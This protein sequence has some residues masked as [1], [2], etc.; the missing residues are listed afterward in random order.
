[1]T[2]HANR[3]H[4]VL[5]QAPAV[6]EGRA[7]ASRPRV[8]SVSCARQRLRA[9]AQHGGEVSL[10]VSVAMIRERSMSLIP[11]RLLPEI[12]HEHRGEHGC[13]DLQSRH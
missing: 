13:D 5:R 6:A 12:G 8:P 1:V 9:E 4:P 7:H 10:L 3:T 11:G 2:A